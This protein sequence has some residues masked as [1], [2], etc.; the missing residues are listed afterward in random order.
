MYIPDKILMRLIIFIIIISFYSI[1]SAYENTIYIWQNQWSP[2]IAE[3]VNRIEPLSNH[4]MVLAGEMKLKSNNL[5]FSIVPV[6]WRYLKNA[7]TITI[8]IRMRSGIANALQDN[9]TI[10]I[11]EGIQN[12]VQKVISDSRIAGMHIDGIQID[13]DCPTAKLT[14]YTKLIKEIKKTFPNLQVSITA[15]PTWMQSKDF[16]ELISS[17][18]YYVLQLHSFEIP[19]GNN[20]SDYI[21]P[22]NNAAGY[23]HQAQSFHKPFYVS[24]PTYGYEV[25][26]SKENKFLGL[27]AEGGIQVLGPGVQHKMMDT[28]PR[29]IISFLKEL[30]GNETTVFRGVCWFR[31]PVSSDRYNWNIKTLERVMNKEYPL[32]SLD[33]DII[34]NSSGLSEVYVTNNGEM[35]LSGKISFDISWDGEKPFYDI[36]GDFESSEL[37]D[38]QGLHLTGKAPRVAQKKIVAW[39]RPSGTKGI[40]LKHSEVNLHENN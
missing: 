8:D 11:T 5:Y 35:N 2:D 19:R 39:F 26:Y 29:E 37:P 4:F 9:K 20:K 33:I 34:P 38:G 32:E 21:F 6:N 27:K 28:N 18:D 7:G 36:L 23:F 17:I 30:E 15:L 12:A 1:T 14:A 16:P 13:Y 22:K 10:L 3:S 24:L 40:L 25:A 31:L